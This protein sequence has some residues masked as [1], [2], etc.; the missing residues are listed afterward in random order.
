MKNLPV[1][2]DFAAG[3]YPSEAQN[4]IPP[5]LHTIM[6]IHYTVNLFTQIRGGGRERSNR[7]KVRG[8]TVHKT[9]SYQHD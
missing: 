9:G 1:K 8:A 6:C 7:E 5:P 2:R 3:V 4:P